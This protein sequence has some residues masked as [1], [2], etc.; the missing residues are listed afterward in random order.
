[1]LVGSSHVGDRLWNKLGEKRVH[2]G[3]WAIQVD[4]TVNGVSV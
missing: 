4:W 3:D 2:A 1:M